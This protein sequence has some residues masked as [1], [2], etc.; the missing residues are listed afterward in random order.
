MEKS[1]RRVILGLK[2]G[3]SRSLG[4]VQMENLG[5]LGNVAPF[6]HAQQGITHWLTS[7]HFLILLSHPHDV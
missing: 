2:E 6:P 7:D 4:G 3:E 1:D 5:D